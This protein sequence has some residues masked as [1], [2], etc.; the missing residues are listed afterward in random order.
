MFGNG[1]GA[2]VPGGSV[3]DQA[4]GVLQQNH[5][6]ENP[7]PPPQIVASLAVP[8]PLRRRCQ[9]ALEGSFLLHVALRQAPRPIRPRRSLVISSPVPPPPS[10][11]PVLLHLPPNHAPRVVRNRCPATRQVLPSHSQVRLQVLLS[12]ENQFLGSPTCAEINGYFRRG[13]FLRSGK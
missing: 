5:Q 12:H 11:H 2:G 9:E 1:G 3:S 10:L 8:T 6:R 13:D 7:S 4:A